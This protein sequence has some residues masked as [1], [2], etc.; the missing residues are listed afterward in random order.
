MMVCQCIAFSKWFVMVMVAAIA[1]ARRRRMSRSGSEYHPMPSIS[2][3]RLP[4]ALSGY[5]KSRFALEARSMRLVKPN[6]SAQPSLRD[7]LQ[8]VRAE[9]PT[10]GGRPDP[11]AG[12]ILLMASGSVNS[13]FP[14][15]KS[16]LT[17]GAQIT[18]LGQLQIAQKT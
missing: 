11:A 3:R 13:S 14:K 15:S 6:T 18:R 4:S 8:L 16:S 10:A 7:Q 17:S 2:S 12:R 9:M 1:V 5:A